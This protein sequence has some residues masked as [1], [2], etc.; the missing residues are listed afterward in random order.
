MLAKAFALLL[1]VATSATSQLP[2]D[3]RASEPYLL[4]YEA[5]QK[6]LKLT[7]DQIARVRKAILDYKAEAK[8]TGWNS[9]KERALVAK[10]LDAAQL[11]R[12]REIS[13][14]SS[15]PI[16]LIVDFIAERIGA[17]PERQDEIQS[18]FHEAM[19]EGFRPMT[20]QINKMAAET[21]RGVSSPEEAEKRSKEVSRRAEEISKSVDE[22]AIQKKAVKKL[23]EGLTPKERAAW[24][25]LLG[26]PFPVDKLKGIPKG[27]D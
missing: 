8:R 24:Q 10:N 6:E 12:L 1:T 23:W 11:K 21:M 5:V 4:K 25:D 19:N 13:M 9:D 22:E 27:W 14:Q 18:S 20:E 16:V 2:F 17:S 15:G 3:A 7:P 26:A